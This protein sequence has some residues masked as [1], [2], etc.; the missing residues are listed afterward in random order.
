MRELIYKTVVSQLDFGN[1]V[2][3]PLDDFLV[4]ASQ[5]EEFAQ[6]LIRICRIVMEN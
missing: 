1:V 6:I 2:E 3:A 4:F 5:S